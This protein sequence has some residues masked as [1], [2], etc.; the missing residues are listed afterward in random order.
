MHNWVQL[1]TGAQERSRRASRC[2]I[3]VLRDGKTVALH[4][5]PAQLPGRAAG[6]TWASRPRRCSSGSARISALSYAG[7]TFGEVLTGS[8]SAVAKLPS[9][10]P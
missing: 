4:A 5:T 3:T 7:N 1:G 9:G 2:P 6:P 10:G 8:V